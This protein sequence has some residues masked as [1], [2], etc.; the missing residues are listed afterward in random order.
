MRPKL[1]KLSLILAEE[2]KRVRKYSEETK[3]SADELARAAAVSWS[4]AGDRSIAEGQAIITQESLAELQKLSEELKA[5]L[6]KPTP[7]V[8]KPV[9]CIKASYTDGR[10]EELYLVNTPVF[11]KNVK[12]VSLNS[13][14]GQAVLG[15]KVGAKVKFQ[16]SSFEILSIE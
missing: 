1:T 8:A 14:L 3:K 2:I 6:D 11:L 12:L 16:N 13:L 7:D 9:C 10:V 5:S 15:K 4:M